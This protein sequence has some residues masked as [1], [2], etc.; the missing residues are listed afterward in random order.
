MNN[1]MAQAGNNDETVRASALALSRQPFARKMEWRN[2]TIGDDKPI[3]F[4]CQ[5]LHKR[6]VTIEQKIPRRTRKPKF[7]RAAAAENF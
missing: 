2:Q 1:E 6:I 4:I 5:T 7:C 3:H